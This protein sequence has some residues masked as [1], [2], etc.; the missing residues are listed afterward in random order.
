MLI[1]DSFLVGIKIGP[2]LLLK[3]GILYFYSII[4]DFIL[5]LVVKKNIINNIVK[6][7]NRISEILVREGN[8]RGREQIRIVLD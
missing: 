3:D 6:K 1:R 4:I 8:F 5:S 7:V 2:I